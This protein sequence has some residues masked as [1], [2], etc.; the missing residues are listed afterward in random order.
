MADKTRAQ[1]ETQVL[2][3][4]LA[5]QRWFA[6]KGEKTARARLADHAL[7]Q[8]DGQS[9]LLGLV[10]V[11]G[12]EAA[13]YF[14]PMVLAWEDTEEERVKS[15]AAA[16]LAKVRQQA[17]VGALAD[18]FADE[19]FVRAT[20]RAIAGAL[21]VPTAG[22]KLRFVPTRVYAELAGDGV[23]ELP[24]RRPQAAS[25]NTTVTL[26]SRLLLKGYRRL[27]AGIVP[28]LEIGRYLTEVARFSNSVPLAGHVEH[29]A[30]DGAVTAIALLQAYVSNQ[31]DGWAYTLGYL[32]R[33]LET[34]PENEEAPAAEVHGAYLALVATLA[35]RTAELHRAFTYTG[36]GPAFDPEPATAQDYAA[37]KARVRDEARA[38][39]QL[40]ERRLPELAG[41]VAEAAQGLL[42]RA[43][44]ILDLV[45]SAPLPRGAML[46]TRHHGDYHLGQV[47]LHENDFVI[48]DFEG[49]PERPL[50]ER[51]GKHTPL[52]DVAGMLR[53]FDYAQWSALR[54]AAKTG[55][56]YA[57]LLPLASAWQAEARR[58]F[59]AAYSTGVTDSGLYGSLDDA[60]GLLRL[61]E[62]EKALYE[63]RY[64]INNRPDW[65]HAPL[66]GIRALLARAG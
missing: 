1:L 30:P 42:A 14:V 16:T 52:R 8:G 32:A 23:T 26:G 46:K 58:A 55:E 49:E 53:S 28:E 11:E 21:E 63:L 13:R 36:A 3:D 12:E 50:G 10:D 29:V 7:W 66:Q 24:I 38:T 48:I 40:L 43:P 27:R 56:D 65:I 31:G 64:E 5:A 44:E 6:G 47:L 62:L 41:A 22:G 19:A 37:W 34:R 15:L 45:E 4:F 25:S 60:A 61:F 54:A 51:R 35:T 33:Y 9:F 59:L 18:A 20:V 2:P 39:F 17:R 57:R